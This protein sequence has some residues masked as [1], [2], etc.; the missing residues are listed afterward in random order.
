M[1]R[2]LAALIIVVFVAIGSVRAADKG[3]ID[4]TFKDK[5]GKE[6]KYVL[7]VPHKYDEKEPAP[8]ILFLHGAGERSGGQ[9]M[10]KEVGLGPAI[11]KYGEAEFPF[12][13]IIPQCDRN[14][15]WRAESPDC[16]RALGMLEDVQKEFKI[17]SKR[18]YLTGLSM[19]GMG[20][21]SLAEKYPE[22]WAA[23]A[24]VCGGIF[25]PGNANPEERTKF[26]SEF[27]A[28]VKHIPCWCFHGNA[29]RAVPVARSREIMA[30][31]WAA[32]ANPGYTEYPG[33]GH[34]SWDAAYG[35]RQLYAW[36][37]EQKLK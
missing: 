25:P 4:K 36:L 34:N 17:D 22:K 16:Q 12:F 9:K 14:S 37:L 27:A 1:N 28:K 20:T 10:P 18:L 35:S 26:I 19:G 8:I 30:A 33:V 5:E 11:T 24:P 3:F 15:F 6:H 29:D 13:V 23:I 31:L 32:G 21:W 2:S 7:F